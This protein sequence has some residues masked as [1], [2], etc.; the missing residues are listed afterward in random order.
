MS[1]KSQPLAKP[2]VDFVSYKFFPA[3]ETKDSSKSLP[4]TTSVTHISPWTL[5]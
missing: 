5:L 2:V 4:T 1:K 3:P